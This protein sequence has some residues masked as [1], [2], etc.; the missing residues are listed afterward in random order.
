[1]QRQDLNGVR[2]PQDLER[3]YD[4][5]SLGTLK[6][7]Y[8]LQKQNLTKVENENNNILK[9]III[10]LEGIL[11]NQ[12]DI[13]LWFFSGTPTLENSPYTDWEN[14][15]EHLGDIYYDKETGEVFIFKLIDNEYLWEKSDSTELVR[16]MALSN[17]EV[18]LGN[19]RK[20]FFD[21]PIPP[22]QNGDWYVKDNELYICQITRGEFE[23]YSENDF[24]IAV[25]YTD[26]TYAIGVG[27]NLKIVSGTVTEIIKDV[28][29]LNTT[30]TNTT[31]LVNEQGNKIGT[32]EV[33][34]SETTQ[35]VEEISQ[36]VSKTMDAQN[37]KI[38][39]ITQTVDEVNSKIKDIADITITGE[40][41]YAVVELDN[42]N[43]SEP[44]TIK[45]R[46][47]GENISYLYPH[48]NLFPSDD[49]FF[50]D[51]TIRFTNKT[52][53]EVFDYEIPADLLYYDENNYD[54]LVLEYDSQTLFVNKKVGYNADGTTY[55]LDNPTII[56][57]P[58]PKI[59]L[60]NGDY[61]ISLLGYNNAYLFTRL[62]AQ[63]IYTTQFATRA[64]VNSEISQTAN[65]IISTVE[66]NYATKKELTTAKSEIKQTTDGISSEVSKKVGNDEVISR[67]NQSAESVK[68]QASKVDVEG[69]ITAINNNKTTT[70]DGDKITTGSITAN[71]IAS[72]TINASKVAS[73]VI[74]TNNFSAQKINAD[75]ITSGTI[76]GNNVTVTNLNASNITGGTLSADKING[77]TISASAINLGS[78]TFTANTSGTIRATSGSIG[79]FSLDGSSGL[80]SS[81]GTIRPNGNLLLYPNYGSARYV[82]SSAM[83]FNAQGGVV[84]ASSS[85]ANISAPSSNLDL[86]ACSGATAYLACMANSDGSGERSAVNCTNGILKFTSSGYCTYNGSTVFGSSSRATK[87]NIVDLTEEQKDE[88]YNLIKNIP[89]KQFDYKKEYGK[90]FNYGFIIEDI[91]DTK[92]NELLHITQA[93]NNEDIKMYSTED[94]ARLELITIQKL[95]NKI[96]TLENKIKELESDKNE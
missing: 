72:N 31:E 76:N 78:G 75:K 56:E 43:Q 68:V 59:E 80:T 74:T 16:A 42:I 19:E 10:N 39:E 37:Q 67:I 34:Q 13:S 86:K 9:S 58:Y 24:I 44:I 55:V 18:T 64:E 65:S 21:T 28:D 48:D 27:E 33:K 1:M 14:Y 62:M 41:N 8:E 36:T 82:L 61:T 26:D 85:N 79:G 69:V 11:E 60:T 71:Q 5:A 77:G 45:I 91:E 90:P 93:E 70:I 23:K 6:K 29:K 81:Y 66:G 84:I 22:Y 94:L 46:P 53:G 57:Y 47:L 38:S 3:K 51:R 25:K 73:D 50:K 40:S 63:N 32:L 52:T 35:T 15:E 2:T 92:L 20:V 96:E 49:L 88:V 17:A 12:S 7:N 30:M 95:I 89:T 4:L 87:E 54:E 83:T